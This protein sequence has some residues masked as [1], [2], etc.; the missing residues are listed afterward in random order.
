MRI[1]DPHFLDDLCPYDTLYLLLE[2]TPRHH[3]VLQCIKAVKT[4]AL[5]LNHT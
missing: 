2:V 1:V 4:E 5:K 3:Q